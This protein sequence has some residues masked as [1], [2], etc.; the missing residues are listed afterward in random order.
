MGRGDAESVLK[1]AE[2]TKDDGA[3]E[4]KR[5]ALNERGETIPAIFK[6]DVEIGGGVQGAEGGG[7]SV[8]DGLPTTTARRRLRRTKTSSISSRR[9]ADGWIRARLNWSSTIRTTARAGRGEIWRS[10]GSRTSSIETKTFTKSSKRIESPSTTSSSTNPPYS[11]DHIEKCVAFA[12]E[13]LTAHGRP[14]MLLLPSYV[15]HKEYYIPAL[16]YGGHPEEK[17]QR[18]SP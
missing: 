14:Y 16:L 9:R 11:A 4:G 2:T 7:T 3:S 1:P 10:S 6:G 5:M 12:A 17:R 18:N 8:R 15:I 13:N